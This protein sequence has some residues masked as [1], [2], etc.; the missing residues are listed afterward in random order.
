MV[1]RTRLLVA[2]I[3]VAPA[4]RTQ[5]PAQSDAEPLKFEVASV[6]PSRADDP[7]P[8]SNSLSGSLNWNSSL[9]MLITIA[10]KLQDYQLVGEPKWVT[11]EYYRIVAKPP[12]GP[13]P[14]DQKTRMDQTSE[15]L[16]SLLIERF[17]LSTHHETRSLPE[18]FLVVAKGGPRLK[19][20]VRGD[21]TFSMRTPPGKIITKGGATIEFLARILS[22][23]LGS[24]VID[25]TGLSRDQL[26]DIQL[27]Y[28]PDESPS[29]TVPPLFTALQEQLGLKLEA[30]KG[31]VDVLVIDHVER[32]S[33]N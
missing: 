4:I 2:L 25:K 3:A 6:K 29:D 13:V 32:P 23:R 19:E 28:A 21:Q 8:E 12:V 18:Y 26:Y 7:A 20:V 16:R 31:P 22:I 30:G 24:P 15:R 14:A 9:K 5:T 33:A 10:Y 17:Q 11:S 27:N 1:Y